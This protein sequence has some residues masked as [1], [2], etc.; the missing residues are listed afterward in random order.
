MSTE[1]I[2]AI[3]SLAGSIITLI[4]G[5]VWQYLLKKKKITLE[6]F[7]AL[8]GDNIYTQCPSCGTELK[9]STLSLYTKDKQ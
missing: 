8:Y 5:A 6:Q 7:I 4:A 2:L 3:T 1:L 9:L